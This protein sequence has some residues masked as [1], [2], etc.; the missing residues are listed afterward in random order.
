M[1]FLDSAL[2][3]WKFDATNK[4]LLP[5]PPQTAKVQQTGLGQLHQLTEYVVWL[6]QK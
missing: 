3:G 5:Q 6:E 4:T 1:F 2:A